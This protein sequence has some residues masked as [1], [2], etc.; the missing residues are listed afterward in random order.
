MLN[1]SNFAS[2]LALLVAASLTMPVDAAT[3]KPP[4]QKPQKQSAQDSLQSQQGQYD[5][6]GAGSSGGDYGN[7]SSNRNNHNSGGSDS[8]SMFKAGNTSLPSGTYAMTNVSTGAAFVVIV[9]DSGDMRAQDA[10]AMNLVDEAKT[11]RNSSKNNSRRNSSGSSNGNPDNNSNY[12]NSNYNDSQYGSRQNSDYGTPGS[13]N[14]YSSNNNNPPPL[15]PPQS[16]PASAV[17]PA[18]AGGHPLLQ[19]ATQSGVYP[20]SQPGS[21]LPNLLTGHNP[22][23]QGQMPNSP[24]G[25]QGMPQQKQG[26]IQGLFNQLNPSAPGQPGSSGIQGK[27]QAELKRQLTKQ[28]MKQGTGGIEQQVRKMIKF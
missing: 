12:N 25:M 21:L 2:A 9:D 17:L 24:G 15:L 8:I 16:T 23:S 27:I 13:N 11:A 3:K 5:S 28:L 1:K 20:S 18:P 19:G 22:L 14:A 7:N 6:G 4:K 10:R 26:G